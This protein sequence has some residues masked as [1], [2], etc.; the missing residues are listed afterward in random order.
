[1]NKKVSKYPLQLAELILMSE[2]NHHLTGACIGQQEH[3][4]YKQVG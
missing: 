3:A 1:M 2:K 4:K